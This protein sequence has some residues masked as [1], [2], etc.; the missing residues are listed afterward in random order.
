MHTR[1]GCE[2]FATDAEVCDSTL[3][4]DRTRHGDRTLS[5]IGRLANHPFVLLV[6]SVSGNGVPN[7]RPNPVMPFAYQIGVALVNPV[8]AATVA[9]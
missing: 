6:A 1:G 2:E 3:P 7:G 5:V 4:N 9:L 8:R